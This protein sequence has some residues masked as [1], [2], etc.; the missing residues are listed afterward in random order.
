[1]PDQ[2]EIETKFVIRDPDS[3]RDR[4]IALGARML[5][6]HLE[7]NIRFDTAEHALTA[8][9]QVLRLRHLEEA[10]ET[11]SVLTVKTPHDDGNPTLAIRREVEMVV[12]DGEAAVAMLDILGFRPY[13]RY[14][15]R[16]ESYVYKDVEIVIDELPIG[17]FAEMEG[18][19]EA[20]IEVCAEIDLNISQGL[21]LS[22]S[23][24]FD[25]VCS[26]L[27][28]KTPDLTFE[29]FSNI[30]IPEHIYTNL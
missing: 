26:E 8:K 21:K 4:L 13:W 12:N 5:G 15:K 16:R 10:G 17:W 14:E 28:L 18:K 3:L 24:I 30:V 27:D 29:A 22:Y 9:K 6:R 25:H 23:E 7:S 1:M 20:I 11:S 2:L 19:P